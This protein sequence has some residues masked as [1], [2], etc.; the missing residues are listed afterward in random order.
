MKLAKKLTLATT[1]I[2]LALNI[3]D[4]RNASAALITYD[5]NVV[6]STF[7]GRGSFTFDDTTFSNDF[8]PAA[9][10]QS[11]SFKFDNESIVYNKTDDIN[12]PNFPLAFQTTL[13]TGNSTIGL[14]FVFDDKNPLSDLSYE[15]VGDDFTAFSRTDLNANPVFGTVSYT[16]VP[17]PATL[18]ACLA[19]CSVAFFAKRK[20]ISLKK[21]R[22]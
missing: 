11:L 5:F 13:L 22:A 12:Y 19:T 14:D 20:G 18:A 1:G 2:F 15:I 17:E 3:L 21:A 9:K 4:I 6:S 8:T 16:K 7:T 10:I